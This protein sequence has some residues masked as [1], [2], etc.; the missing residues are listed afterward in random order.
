MCEAPPSFSLPGSRH[1]SDACGTGED[2]KTELG[3]NTVRTI[4]DLFPNVDNHRV[5]ANYPDIKDDCSGPAISKFLPHFYHRTALMAGKTREHEGRNRVRIGCRNHS[6][7]KQ[8]TP[9]SSAHQPSS[10]PHSRTARQLWAG[11]VRPRRHQ[12][13]GLILRPRRSLRAAPGTETTS[14]PVMRSGRS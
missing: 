1:V 9:A 12:L 10:S 14:Q 6:Q 8:P 11:W 3:R 13:P 7:A 4:Y 5:P 2:G